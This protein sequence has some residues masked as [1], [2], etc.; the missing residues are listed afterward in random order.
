MNTG[1]WKGVASIPGS[2]K[3]VQWFRKSCILT[4]CSNIKAVPVY[5]PFWV[6]IIW[7]Q[8]FQLPKIL[9]FRRTRM[10]STFSKL[11]LVAQRSDVRTP[12]SFFDSLDLNYAIVNLE[13]V[14]FKWEKGSVSFFKPFTEI[15]LLPTCCSQLMYYFALFEKVW[16]EI[17]YAAREQI[18]KSDFCYSFRLH[19]TPQTHNHLR[20]F[21]LSCVIYYY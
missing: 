4:S 3:F 14:I 19:F 13:K 2:D 15:T 16:K 11:V 9:N 1:V 21:L 7:S 5:L 10:L 12:F 6:L 20:Y 18:L 17:S 8:P